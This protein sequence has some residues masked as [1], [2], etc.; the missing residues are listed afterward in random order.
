M[1]WPNGLFVYV[2]IWWLV[3]FMV[4]PWGMW[5]PNNRKKDPVEDVPDKWHIWKKIF[6]TTAISA[7]F[8]LLIHFLLETGLLSFHAPG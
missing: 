6:V 8:W 3:L 5:Q 2:V 7:G 1:T 4:P